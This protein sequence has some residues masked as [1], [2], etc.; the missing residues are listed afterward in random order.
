M[1]I[2]KNDSQS[3]HK[4]KRKPESFPGAEERW[5]GGI[6]AKLIAMRDKIPNAELE[7]MQK[8]ATLRC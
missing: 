7:T 2:L 6:K 5:E 1:D 3:A 8:K 4:A